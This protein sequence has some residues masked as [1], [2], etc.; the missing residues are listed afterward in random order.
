MAVVLFRTFPT[1]WQFLKWILLC[2]LLQF[3]VS[4][5]HTTSY[6]GFQYSFRIIPKLRNSLLINL[7]LMF[8]SL[9]IDSFL[10]FGS[11]PKYSE[12]KTQFAFSYNGKWL[13]HENEKKRL[14]SNN[15]RENIHGSLL[16]T[17]GTSQHLLAKFF[18]PV[19]KLDRQLPQSLN[20][21]IY[22]KA[23]AK[24]NNFLRHQ[25]RKT[26]VQQLQPKTA[27]QTTRKDF[28]FRDVI[29]KERLNSYGK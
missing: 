2:Y 21:P 5:L 17:A 14:D 19:K 25:K 23:T 10:A 27:D 9:Q 4:D 16:L 13:F 26:S 6:L 1:N 7:I 24:R 8:I 29:R 22:Q 18:K 28:V 12:L 3:W 20:S 11:Q 15:Q